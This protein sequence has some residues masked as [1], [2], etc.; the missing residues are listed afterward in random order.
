MQ[1]LDYVGCNG[2]RAFVNA[3]DF[4]NGDAQEWERWRDRL[5]DKFG[6]SDVGG[7]SVDSKDEW[8]SARAFTRAQA[9][10]S[11]DYL[12]WLEEGKSSRGMDWA[13]IFR[14]GNKDM[15]GSFFSQLEQR[16]IR[17][18]GLWDMRCRALRMETFLYSKPMYWNERWE[19]WHL[20]YV[21]GLMMA[22]WDVD[23]VEVYN[24]PDLDLKRYGCIDND[25]FKD[26]LR[27]RSDAVRAAY[28]DAGRSVRIH[29]GSFTRGWDDKMSPIVAENQR[30]PFPDDDFMESFR[31][32]EDGMDAYDD[33]MDA[34]EREFKLGDNYA[35]H[36]YGS[37]SSKSCSEYGPMCKHENGYSVAKNAQRAL[38][39]L[40]EKHNVR[41]MD[42]SIT[43]FNC[44]TA[45]WSD[46]KGHEYFVGKNVVDYGATATCLASQFSGF[47]KQGAG[48]NYH[49]V[50]VHKFM[51]TKS[52]GTTA[53][54]AK[55]G[56]TFGNFN[57]LKGDE[58][59]DMIGGISRTGMSLRQACTKAGFGN[60]VY[61]FSSYDGKNINE[62]LNRFNMWTVKQ[63]N[64]AHIFAMNDDWV[65]TNAQISVQRLNPEPNQPYWVTAISDSA[66]AE[67]TQRSDTGGNKDF[68]LDMPKETFKVITVPTVS[69]HWETIYAIRDGDISTQRYGPG[70]KKTLRVATYPGSASVAMVAYDKGD[71]QVVGANIELTVESATNTRQQVLTVVGWRGGFDEGYQPWERTPF[72]KEKSNDMGKN[73]AGNFLNWDQV[74]I[75]GYVTVRGNAKSGDRVSLDVTDWIDRMGPDY[76]IAVMRLVRHD[77]SP[78]GGDHQVPGDKLDG[79]YI[80]YSREAD[81]ENDRPKLFVAVRD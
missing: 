23:E 17:V 35:L 57:D 41:D 27:I 26:L 38:W 10:K 24:E 52:M 73:I 75:L 60:D 56:L 9:K 49:L 29:V 6:K 8:L 19:E 7:W 43:E 50:N 66:F 65:S 74:D 40:A 46:K 4:V 51:Q 53:G 39:R 79:E 15:K 71:R 78:E 22:K 68:Y 61:G 12:R 13:E 67:V 31:D 36:D 59:V 70:N 54:V 62:D 5:G 77:D 30:T 55:N 44:Y 16:G 48:K 45:A 58:Q 34:Y 14:G 21:G 63:G 11:G 76:N 32:G 81:N 42:I 18:L 20:Y 3:A 28:E 72:L 47:F 1:W 25:R 80:F 69:S 64:L 37:F 33:G 2:V